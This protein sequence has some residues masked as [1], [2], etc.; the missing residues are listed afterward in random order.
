MLKLRPTNTIHDSIQ[1][2]KRVSPH[3]SII[4]FQTP[5]DFIPR[6]LERADNQRATAFFTMEQFVVQLMDGSALS[7]LSPCEE[8]LSRPQNRQKESG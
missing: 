6:I 8:N 7:S 5:E 1:Y 2:L 3:K 4:P